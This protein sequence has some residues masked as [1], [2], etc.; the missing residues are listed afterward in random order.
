[1]G[2]GSDES[3]SGREEVDILLVGASKL[4][5]FAIYPRMYNRWTYIQCHW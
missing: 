3:E 1:M 2:S 5:T 4:N